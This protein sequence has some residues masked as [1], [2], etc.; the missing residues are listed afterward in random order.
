[1]CRDNPQGELLKAE[2]IGFLGCLSSACAFPDSSLGF[3][4]AGGRTFFCFAK[5]EVAKEKATPG[6]A[7][8][9][10][11][12]PAL[13]EAGGGCGTRLRL[14]QSSP[15]FRR[16]LR[17]S[18]LHTGPKGGLDQAGFRKMVCCGQPG[19]MPKNEGKAS[20]A[21]K[22]TKLNPTPRHSVVGGSPGSAWIPAYYGM[23]GQLFQHGSFLRAP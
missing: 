12:S 8:G 19:K 2:S 15:F 21:R 13:L 9:C 10:A 18:A 11:N 20:G 22:N 6:Y 14:R 1:M 7:V 17:C 3:R 16:L 23:T 5:R 4:L